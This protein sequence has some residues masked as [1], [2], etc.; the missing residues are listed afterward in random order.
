MSEASLLL[1]SCDLLSFIIILEPFRALNKR[2]RETDRNNFFVTTGWVFESIGK[3]LFFFAGFFLHNDNLVYS[4]F[5]MIRI[6][7]HIPVSFCCSVSL[8]RETDCRSVDRSAASHRT[9]FPAVVL[10]VRASTR[11]PSPS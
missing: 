6:H 11:S 9:H 10:F 4:V 5:C 3:V 2:E 7:K 8:C 1:G